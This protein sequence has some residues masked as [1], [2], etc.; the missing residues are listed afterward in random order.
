MAG[1]LVPSDRVWEADWYS[2]GLN[3]FGGRVDQVIPCGYPA[4]ARI[5]HPA[6]D[7]SGD[8]RRWSDVATWSGTV[9]HPLAQFHAIAGRWEYER[10]K[11]VGWPGENPDK[12][13]LTPRQLR[14]LCQ[15]LARHTT[16]PDRCWLTVW[17]GYGNLP[18][19]WERTAPRVHQPHRA[20]YIF[21]RRLDEVLEFSA[22][23]A[24]IGWDQ[25][26]LPASM[27]YLE[28]TG[29]S[30]GHDGP[31]NQAEQHTEEPTS[32]QSPNQ[33]WPQDHA[34]CVATEIDFDSTLVAGTDSLISEI[35]THQQ[36]E[37]FAVDQTDNLTHEGD[38]INPRPLAAD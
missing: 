15:I 24:R 7:V 27:G 11:P 31:P 12:G 21:Q 37:A 36:L 28:T 32:I 22:Q 18:Q 23:V 14:V 33:W 25:D 8:E 2:A 35:T 30:M 20:Y 1:Q 19:A 4:Y 6:R 29:S 26:P 5:L 17:E 16:T 3:G 13:T 38:K 9:L 10:R 34:W